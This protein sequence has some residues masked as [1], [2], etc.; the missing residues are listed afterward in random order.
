MSN[1]NR[2][3]IKEIAKKAIQGYE[4]AT[5]PAQRQ[6]YLN[7]YNNALDKLK[8]IKKQSEASIPDKISSSPVAEALEAVGAF[9]GATL[10][11][12]NDVGLGAN[13]ALTGLVSAVPEMV[14]LAA[15]TFE[16]ASEAVGLPVDT[17]L[18]RG[19]FYNW[20][21]QYTG[22]DQG[23]K[24]VFGN[25]FETVGEA[26]TM[27]A[28]SGP[29]AP[30]VFMAEMVRQT[31]AD[32]VRYY[33]PNSEGAMTTASVLE[34]MPLSRAEIT[35]APSNTARGVNEVGLAQRLAD[36]KAETLRQQNSPAQATADKLAMETASAS[37][38]GYGYTRGQSTGNDITIALEN[39][40]ATSPE[41]GV[42]VDLEA[43]NAQNFVDW[44]QKSFGID[45][46]LQPDLLAKGLKNSYEVFKRKSQD[47]FKTTTR[48]AF[49]NVG[50]DVVFDA[51]Q[52][53]GVVDGLIKKYKLDTPTITE[54]NTALMNSLNAYKE[55]LM[56]FKE[57]PVYTTQKVNGINRRVQSGTEK[58]PVG[59]KEL[60][61]QEVQSML[62]DIGQMA[63]QGTVPAFAGVDIGYTKA[64]ARQLG[65][66]V[67]DM[68]DVASASGSQSATALTQARQTYNKALKDMQAVSDLPFIQLMDKPLSM[69][70]D[71]DLLSTFQQLD[72]RGQ[73][74]AL[75]LLKSDAP[76]TIPLLRNNVLKDLFEGAR[77]DVT[78][79]SKT[80]Q[81][82]TYDLGK[83]TKGLEDLQK[84]PL[85]Q[86]ADAK[87]AFNQY[88]ALHKPIL[89]KLIV[90][91]GVAARAPE[92]NM[93]LQ[94]TRLYSEI[95]GFVAGTAARYSGQVI[96][97]VAEG[98]IRM[99]AD[100]RAMA[101]MAVTP[102]M[103]V[104]I[105]KAL[106]KRRLTK[107]EAK[108]YQGFLDGYRTQL[109]VDIGQEDPEPQL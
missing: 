79:S 91:K 69:I 78:G 15:D 84:N 93:V 76:E 57:V 60:T 24:S 8:A 38:L 11:V 41:G 98:T 18:D 56:T 29:A 99:L 31:V 49:N 81:V 67:K 97:R 90:S 88:K 58:V 86:D 73:G 7:T 3:Q 14:N 66:G 103:P 47:A 72:T 36:Q 106:N 108:K 12:L 109:A 44:T 23:P 53:G 74:V 35:G 92:E 52:I 71:A 25:A 10:D 80:E 59:Y 30:Y 105:H 77:K 61:A 32:G 4:S 51:S 83:V 27:A 94:A 50:D 101:K 22:A 75:A 28:V 96:E 54:A 82:T 63:F 65:A 39:K 107:E 55:S 21:S 16:E 70:S 85:F 13:K 64:I 102:D 62:Q 26:G 68:L 1:T 5:D 2:E 9:G 46:S 33:L 87:K 19:T 100:D 17:G 95:A 20:L 34:M 40:L 45:A 6:E 43:K 37:E 104:I 48:N 42:L 89:E